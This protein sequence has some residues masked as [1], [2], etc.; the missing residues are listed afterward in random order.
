VT[1]DPALFSDDTRAH[2][3]LLKNQTAVPKLAAVAAGACGRNS[4]R[5]WWDYFQTN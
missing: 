3:L 1:L 2:R 5:N 4:L